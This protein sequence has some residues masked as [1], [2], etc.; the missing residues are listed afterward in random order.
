VELPPLHTVS[1]H[2]VVTFALATPE[3]L[4]FVQET[5]KQVFLQTDGCITERVGNREGTHSQYKTHKRNRYDRHRKR[6]SSTPCTYFKGLGNTETTS[7]RAEF[8][9]SVYKCNSN[10]RH[11]GAAPWVVVHD[12][13]PLDCMKGWKFKTMN[14]KNF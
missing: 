13:S 12:M 11:E 9:S 5:V 14:K 1:L 3:T 2:V 6:L 8:A 10:I 4:I 7:S